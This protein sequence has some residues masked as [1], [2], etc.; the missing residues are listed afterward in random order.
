MTINTGSSSL[1]AALYPASPHGNAIL[2]IHV[3]RIGASGGRMRIERGDGSKILDRPHDASNHETALRTTLTWMKEQGYGDALTAVGHRVVHG[4]RDH[5]EPQ[6]VTDSLLAALRNLIPIDS[7]HLPQAIA[8][9]DAVSDNFPATLQVACFDTA[10]HRHIPRVA[11]MYALPRH[12]ERA[13]II[14]YGF[15]GLSY[16]YVMQRLAA[17]DPTAPRQRII[18]AHL[19]NGASM[20][21]VRH[22][23]SIDTTMGFTPTGGLMMGTRTGDIDPGVILYLLQADAMEPAAVNTLVNREAG[24]LGVSETSQDMH[25]L[26]EAEAVD[27]RAAEAVHLFCYQATKFVGALAAVLGGVDTL[28]FT[29]GIGENSARVRQRICA[30]LEFLGIRVDDDRNNRNASVISDPGTPVTVRVV[31]TDEDRMIATHTWS[32]LRERGKARV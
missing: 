11:Q 5:T 3:D 30:T 7:N 29:G 31:E 13:G 12:V 24:L 22:G 19:G 18:I 27:A 21:A 25:D 15:H 9:I 17:I 2:T 32:L 8:A 20:V 4:G 26:L 23:R 16:E 1:K 10:F 14:R 28:V 6:I